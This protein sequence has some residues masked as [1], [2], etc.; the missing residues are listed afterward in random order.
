MRKKPALQIGL[1][2]AGLAIMI[3]TYLLIIPYLKVAEP[4]E[5]RPEAYPYIVFNPLGFLIGLLM[6][7]LPCL[8]QA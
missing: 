2:L 7:L 6:F 3:V 1:H 4:K 5:T 8:L